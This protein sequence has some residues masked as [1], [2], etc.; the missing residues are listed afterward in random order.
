VEE[1]Y[2]VSPSPENPTM[3]QIKHHKEKKIKKAK[4]KAC[5]FADISYL[6]FTRIMNSPKEIWDYE[7]YEGNEHVCGM[8]VLNLMREFEM[9]KIKKFKTIKGYSDRLFG[10]AN[11]VR[12]LRT[13]FANSNC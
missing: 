12:L 11:K 13:T 2:E 10:I 3:V 9:Q 1:D 5:L 4:A 6:I 8:Q 7:E